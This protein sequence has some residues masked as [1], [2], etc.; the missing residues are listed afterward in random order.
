MFGDLST[1][2]GNKKTAQHV[3]EE[4]L[5]QIRAFLVNEDEEFFKEKENARVHDAWGDDD[6]ESNVYRVLLYGTAFEADTTRYLAL[7]AISGTLHNDL[8]KEE[9][10]DTF[11]VCMLRIYASFTTL[12][13]SI[14]M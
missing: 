10:P 4:W 14:T 12:K 1:E 5:A 7:R 9:L 2:P 13:L 6:E 11:K 8:L 3:L